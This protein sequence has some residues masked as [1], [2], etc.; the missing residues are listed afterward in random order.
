MLG[1]IE[2]LKESIKVFRE[3]AQTYLTI[4]APL[5]LLA[6]ILVLVTPEPFKKLISTYNFPANEINQQNYALASIVSIINSVLTVILTIGLYTAIAHR[7]EKLSAME[8]IK[9]GLK[10]FWPYLWVSILVSAVSLGASV[11]LIVPGIIVAIM[12]FCA[13]YIYLSENI[14]GLEAL[15]RSRAYTR[16][17]G[18][19]IFGRF[20]AMLILYIPIVIVAAIFGRFGDIFSPIF[21]VYFATYTIL[22]YENLRNMNPNVDSKTP[23][24]TRKYFKILAVISPI[25]A[26]VGVLTS[27]ALLAI[28]PAALLKKSRDTVRLQDLLGLKIGVETYYQEN[29][30]YPTSLNQVI[31]NSGLHKTDPST[32]LPYQYKITPDGSYQICAAMEDKTMYPDLKHCLT[33]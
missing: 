9:L 29:G 1:P 27:V 30:K 7:D 10:K 33:E 16:G 12:I 13:P 6:L 5:I 17:H 20:L 3:N 2:L 25:V 32:Q 31:I 18:L 28:N 8:Y 11:F 15:V 23:S 22:M 4:I 14:G 21:V 19:G 24:K 26:I